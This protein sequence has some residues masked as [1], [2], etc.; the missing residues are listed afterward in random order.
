VGGR[1]S[2]LVEARSSM[3]MGGFRARRGDVPGARDSLVPARAAREKESPP[4]G[5]VLDGLQSMPLGRELPPRNLFVG[6]FF[7]AGTTIAKAH[8]GLGSKYCTGVAL[9]ISPV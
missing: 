5:L 3:Q 1:V 7:L 8:W 4:A 2:G 6:C 9:P